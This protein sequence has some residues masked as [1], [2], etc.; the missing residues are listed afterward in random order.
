MMQ[1]MN[2]IDAFKIRF[3]EQFPEYGDKP[4]YEVFH[5]DLTEKAANELLKLVLEGKKL[6]TA[7]SLYAYQIEN[8]K[9]P[10]PGDL[11]IVTDFFNVPYAV[12]KT[13]SLTILPFGKM[14]YE[15]CKREG[16]DD[17]LE[18]WNKNHT[19]FFTEESKILG[20]KFNQEMPVVFEDFI[21]LYKEDYC[22]KV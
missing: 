6:A 22:E 18:S 4:I 16:E 17:S 19:K 14:T 3:I 12:I 15:I 1:T 20:Y 8:E 11:S 21:V 13:M 9:L 7:S 5:F 2:K 10:M